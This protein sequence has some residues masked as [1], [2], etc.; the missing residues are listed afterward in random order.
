[1]P[2]PPTEPFTGTLDIPVGERDG[3]QSVFT[4]DKEGKAKVDIRFERCLELGNDQLMSGLAIA[5]HSDNKTYASS[6]GPFGKASHVQL[7][8]ML[9]NKKDL[10][11]N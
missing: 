6:A 11:N 5:Y 7:F 4:T 1:M 3:S 8:A 10:P 2:A 9:P